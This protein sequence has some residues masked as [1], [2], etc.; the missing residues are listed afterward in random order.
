MLRPIL[1]ACALC[2]AGLAPS[3]WAQC[4]PKTTVNDTLYN[5]D[6]SPAAGRVVIAWPTFQIGACQVIAGQAT[7]TVASGDF[8]VQLYPNDAAVPAGTSY[9]ATYYLK[10]GRITTEY[11]V[12]PTSASPVSLAAV[13]SSSVP[14][15]TVMFGQGQVTNLVPDLARKIELPAPCPAGK[16]LQANGSSSPPQV[17]CVD[18]TGAPL[19]S[20]TQSGTVKT[21][22]DEADPRVYTKASTDSMLA[23]KAN[24]SH[25]HA[26]ADI[27]S[28]VLDPARLPAPS[29]TTLGGVRSGTCSGF[30][31][32]TGINTTGQI[33]CGADQTGGSGS[34]HQVNG[35]NLAAGDP[36]NFQDTATL[37]FTNPSAG[38]IQAGVKDG[39]ITASKLSVASPTGAQLSGV[40][41]ANIPAG[42]LSPDRTS[43]TAEVQTNKGAANGYASLNASQKVVQDPANAQTTAAAAKIPIAGGGGTIDDA[44]LSAGV[45][46]LGATIELDSGEVTNTLPPSKGG[47]GANNAA[48]SGRYPRGD[49]TNFVTS[50]VA[51]AGAGSCTNQFVRATNDNAQPTCATVQK[52]DAAGTFIHTDQSNAYTTGTQDFESGSVTRPFRRLAFSSFPGSCTPNREFLERSDPATA[53]QVLY[54]CNAAGNGWDLVGDGGGG[55]SGVPNPSANGM[56]ACAGTNC[57]TSAARTITAGSGASVTNGDG[58]GG[59]PTV[60]AKSYYVKVTNCT[61][62]GNCTGA[63]EV[64]AASGEQGTNE[65]AFASNYQ[66]PAND[67]VAGVTYIVTACFKHTTSGSAPNLQVRARLQ[68][69]GP[70]NVEFYVSG[71][72]TP[73]NNQTTKGWCES[74]LIQGTGSASATASVEATGPVRDWVTAATGTGATQNTVDQPVTVDTTA[75]QTIEITAKWSAATTG[76]FIQLRQFYVQRVTQ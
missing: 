23:G 74:W 41:D 46:K 9:R 27:T 60:A 45:T 13:R 18:G 61:T 20:S 26:T 68:K 64:N 40:G 48:T 57:S 15:P 65:I 59:N 55:G 52:A 58:V 54:V 11:W 63:N 70:T 72:Q 34:Q 32:V 22:V 33:T 67:L 7:V 69:S 76:N 17:S 4:P 25:P 10:S 39:S 38:N 19:S 66:I 49:G 31:K 1:L 3:A 62:E 51:A 35:T 44:W 8:S 24:A 73:G 71:N 14:V 47:T 42:A 30:D 50:S 75:A 29:A 21:D 16:F 53:G 37:A 36:V 28:G 6:G 56:V 43:G 12:V 2:S 5:A